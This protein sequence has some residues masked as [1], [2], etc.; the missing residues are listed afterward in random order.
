MFEIRKIAF[1]DWDAYRLSS[2]D[3]NQELC[4]VPGLG[5]CL[6][7]L[8]LGGWAILDACATPKDMAINR[9]AKSALL[10][11]FPNRLSQG[12]YEWEGQRYQFPI[13]DVPANNALHGFGM[14]QPMK[15][16]AAEA[17]EAQAR[18]R[19]Q[20]DYAGEL[21]YYPFPFQFEVEFILGEGSLEVELSVRNTGSQALPFGMGWHP[22]FRLTPKVDE[23]ILQMPPCDLVGV[24]AEMIPT[25]KRYA[26]DT[27]AEPKRIGAEVLDNAFAL[28]QTEGRASIHLSNEG[29]GLH[30][31]Q[32]CGPGRFPFVQLFTPPNRSALAIEP[33][34]CNIDAFNNGQGLM[35]VLPG[36]QRAARFGVILT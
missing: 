33:M 13:N 29:Y 22:Y 30:Y 3:G 36:E 32:E 25:G 12:Q 31:W 14:Q 9:W 4:A 27:F 34:S 35:R 2:L 10:Y 7:N 8:S 20:F 23:L 18:L 16:I 15:V 5:S 17:D 24:D 19:C 11:P 28:H 21:P 26:Y 1:G 6:R